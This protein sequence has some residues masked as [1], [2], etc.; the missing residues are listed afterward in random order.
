MRRCT[1]PRWR[2][3]TATCTVRQSD[4]G[5]D[6]GFYDNQTMMLLMIT[7]I[8]LFSLEAS[9]RHHVALIFVE[10]RSW[11]AQPILY[12]YV[13]SMLLLMLLMYVGVAAVVVNV[14][15]LAEQQPQ[16]QKQQHLRLQLQ[17]LLLVLQ[18]LLLLL[19]IILAAAAAAAAVSAVV[20]VVLAVMAAA[21]CVASLHS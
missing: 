20:I 14:T 9:S 11:L 21:G 16:Q 19:F 15:S 12:R 5:S 13:A 17:L 8:P 1:R 18:M 6:G 7:T 10:W 2:D 3:K 4:S